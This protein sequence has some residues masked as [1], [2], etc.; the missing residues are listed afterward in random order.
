MAEA[1][2]DRAKARVEELRDQI[3][4][5]NHRYYVLD[6]PEVS[7]FEYDALLRELIALEQEHPE[8]LQADSPSQRVGGD[9]SARFAPAVHSE[10]LLS[11]D[12]VF[13]DE[14]L[15]AWAARIVKSLGFAPQYVCEPKI[16]GVSLAVTYQDGKLT[17]GATRGNGEVGEDVTANART[18]RSLPMRLRGEELPSWFEVRTEV[19]LRVADFE[20]I[21]RELG[22]AGKPLFA[23]PRNTAAG[24][25][26]QKDPQV[27]AKRP[28]QVYAHGLIRVEPTMP[29]SY[30]EA[31][32]VVRDL[33]LP[34]HPEA[35]HCRD[36]DEVRS[37][38]RNLTARRHDLAHEVDGVVIKVDSFDAQRQLGAT[39]KAPRWAI[40][41]KLPPEERNTVLKDIMVSVGRTGAVTPF[42]VLEPVRVGGVTVSMAT[43]H[44]EDEVE[45]KGVLLGDTVVVRRA[46]DVI[47]EVVAP[48]T[49]L[50]SG[51]ERRFAMPKLCPACQS[52]LV[53]P[54][55]EAVTRCPNPSCPAQ[56]WGRLVHFASRDAMDIEHL[57]ERTA[58]ELLD[59]KLVEDAADVFMLSE[60]DLSELRNFKR[61]SISNL[62]A[63]IEQAKHRPID[64]LLFGLGIRHVGATAAKVLADAFES[65]ER[66]ATASE[67]DIA[68]VP[69]VGPVIATS[70][71]DYFAKPESQMLLAKLKRADVR[72][73]ESRK[74]V[75]GHLSGKTFVITGTLAGLSREAAGG[76]ITE[77]GGKVTQSVSKRTTYLVVG[78][79]PGSKLA[80]AEKLGVERITEAQFLAILNSSG[81]AAP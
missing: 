14:E 69:G 8:L 41:Y 68:S 73:E 15:E 2:R 60:D 45:R 11:L 56:A 6:A 50:R 76:R 10:R 72:L 59:R 7:D 65:L 44:N 20:V 81:D 52:D 61:R 9:P 4:H 63:A 42:A 21:N 39:A 79:S 30:L 29:P 43:L 12:N 5:H 49:S 31:L 24:L 71:R 32:E 17:R 80:K 54:E 55:G 62:L 37:Y 34:T 27:T 16:D 70:V 64:R 3:E 28:L 75:E 66:I 36:L 19:Y 78:E 26:R 58:Q 25:L 74:P 46:G 13:D 23:N 18:I 53:R 77:H 33:G 35:R 51:T 47:P 22:E 38:V 67:E 1:T 40:A 57:G 48:V